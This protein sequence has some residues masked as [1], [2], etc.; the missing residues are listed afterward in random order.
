M[1][2]K[3][4]G[5]HALLTAAIAAL[6]EDH[7]HLAATAPADPQAQAAALEAAGEDVAILARALEVLLRRGGGQ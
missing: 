3:P 5:A 1:T 7:A 2:A 4:P 6:L